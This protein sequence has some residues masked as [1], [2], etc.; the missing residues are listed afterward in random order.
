LAAIDLFRK[1]KDPREFAAGTT[2]FKAE[3]PGDVMYVVLEG[4]VDIHRK[5]QVLETVKVG[6]LFGEMAL[7]DNMPRSAAAM[8]R[9]ACKLAV[10]DQERFLSLIQSTPAFAIQIMTV[11]SERLRRLNEQIG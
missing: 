9:T 7:V 6:G 8:T 10:V 3:E 1:E 2:I 11:M 4:E 5:D